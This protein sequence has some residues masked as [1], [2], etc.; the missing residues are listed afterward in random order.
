MDYYIV[1]VKDDNDWARWQVE[2][3]SKEDVTNIFREYGLT[4]SNATLLE[5]SVKIPLGG[6]MTIEN[7]TDIVLLACDRCGELGSF[8]SPFDDGTYPALYSMLT[9]EDGIYCNDCIPSWWNEV[10]EGNE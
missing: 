3:E 7:K 8:A 4:Q 6:T 10:L 1:I 2:A 5:S 9:L